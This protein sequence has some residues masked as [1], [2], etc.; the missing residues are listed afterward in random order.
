M[1]G[2]VTFDNI[3]SLACQLCIFIA[4]VFRFFFPVTLSSTAIII[5]A[6]AHLAFVLPHFSSISFLSFLVRLPRF[7]NSEP[8]WT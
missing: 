8:I 2:R 1:L 3:G 7:I 5:G 6:L 4:V